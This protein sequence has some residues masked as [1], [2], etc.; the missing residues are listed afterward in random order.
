VEK[1]IKNVKKHAL[2]KNVKTFITS[3][4]VCVVY[5]SH[6]CFKV[7]FSCAHVFMGTNPSLGLVFGS[8]RE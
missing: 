8:Q 3:M 6:W 2:N 7:Y 4:L 1:K 5:D